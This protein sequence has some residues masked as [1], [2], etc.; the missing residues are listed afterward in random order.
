MWQWLSIATI[1]IK[2]ATLPAHAA[3]SSAGPAS[4]AEARILWEDGV[5]AY[6]AGRFQPAVNALSRYVDR[7]P[8]EKGYLDA[9]R[10][11]GIAEFRIGHA[12]EAIA[13]LSFFVQAKAQ[14]REGLAARVWLG[15]AYLKLE[16]FSE[17]FLTSEEIEKQQKAASA[18]T[19]AQGLLLKSWALIGLG[20]D[21]RAS[22]TATSISKLEAVAEKPELQG[23]LARVDLRIK[24]RQCARLPSAK[25]LDEGQVRDQLNR[26]GGCLSEALLIGKR[27]ADAG[28]ESS[29]NPAVTELKTAI[30]DYR[31]SCL[32]P[33]EP[34][35]I[36]PEDRS[37]DQKKKYRA[38]LVELLKHECQTKLAES[39]KLLSDW[40]NSIS[41]ALLPE[42]GGA[43]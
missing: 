32:N 22:T 37:E 7:Y 6:K 3:D 30:L 18:N 23:E 40:H 39:K 15:R 33:P 24:L 19:F 17:A 13:P 14:T 8:G 34:P 31:V 16:K 20:Q 9:H 21:E 29:V 28:D 35:R 4:Q 27:V 42:L 43:S 36:K 1:G 25:V 2:L 5:A 10:M 12:D 38:E 11:L 26:R 41:K